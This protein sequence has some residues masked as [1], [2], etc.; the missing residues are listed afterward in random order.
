MTIEQLEKANEIHKKLKEKK[1]FLK[2][3]DSP[4]SNCIRAYDDDGYRD[5][6]K[7]RYIYL[8]NEKCLSDFIRSYVCGQIAE[9]EKE[10]EEL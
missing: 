1:D 10:L 6:S 2:A 7:I 9:L 5:S 4:F 8:E 3:F